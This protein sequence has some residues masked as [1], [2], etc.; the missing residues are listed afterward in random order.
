[1]KRAWIITGAGA[2]LGAG[3]G[4]LYW[5]YVGCTGGGCSITSSPANSSIY[6]AVMIGL[7]VNTIVSPKSGRGTTTTDQQ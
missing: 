1:M 3:L 7:L 2:A 5:R 6:G 4:W